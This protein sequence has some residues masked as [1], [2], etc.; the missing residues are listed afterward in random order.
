M[1]RKAGKNIRIRQLKRKEQIIFDEQSNKGKEA[2]SNDIIFD[3]KKKI[4]SLHHLIG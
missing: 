2:Y 1:K 3:F 4:Y